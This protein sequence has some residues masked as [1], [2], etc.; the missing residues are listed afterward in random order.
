MELPY[1]DIARQSRQSIAER[2]SL[3]RRLALGTER[4]LEWLA[5]YPPY[6]PLVEDWSYLNEYRRPE[7]PGRRDD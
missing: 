1:R 6:S 7:V 2:P 4:L 5:A 3:W